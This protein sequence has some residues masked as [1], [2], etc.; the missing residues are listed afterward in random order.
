MPRSLA[1]EDSGVREARYQSEAA[2]KSWKDHYGDCLA[3]A[4][5]KSAA[6]RYLCDDGLKLR[7]A[8][9]PCIRKLREERTDAAKPSPDQQALFDLDGNWL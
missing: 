6:G 1:I 4:V 2:T 9:D 5:S 7:N 3:C 8:H